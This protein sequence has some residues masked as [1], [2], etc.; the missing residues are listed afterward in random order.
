M[1]DRTFSITR[2]V[3]PALPYQHFQLR[4][5]I[6]EGWLSRE[7]TGQKATTNEPAAGDQDLGA[8]IIGVYSIWDDVLKYVFHTSSDNT[9]PPW[10]PGSELATIEYRFADFEP[11]KLP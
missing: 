2:L 3:S 5:P 7:A 10:Q 11:R 1:L 6:S 9:M 4:K 8:L